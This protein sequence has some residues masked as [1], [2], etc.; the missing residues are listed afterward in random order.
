MARVT[1]FVPFIWAGLSRRP[2]RTVLGLVAVTMAF[3][4]YGLALGEAEGFA[5]AAAARHVDIGQGFLLG[6]L[7]VSAIGM[8]LILFLTANAMAQGVRLRIGE[9]G[10]LKAIGYSHRLILLLVMAEAA[11]PCLGGAV[12]GLTFAPLL[13]GLLKLLLP[14]L[15]IFPAL[16]YTPAMLATAA[17]LA[18]LIGA[19]SGALPA[20]R[21]IRLE[22][23]AA[24]AGGPMA[25]SRRETGETRQ[26]RETIAAAAPDGDGGLARVAKADLH[27][28]RQIIVV[29]RIGLSTLRYRIKGGLVIVVSIGVMA[30]VMLGFLSGAEGIKIG[31]LGSG[32]LD[33]V[34]IHQMARW[35]PHL[36]MWDSHLPDNAMTIAQAAPGVARGRNGAKLVVPL[37]YSGLHMIKR[38]NGNE[39]NT[40]LI[41]AGS[42]W[43]DATPGL[44]LLW[45]RM[46]HRGARELIAGRNALGKF[47][48]LDSHTVEYKKASWKIVGGF[49]TGDWWDGYLVGDIETVQAAAKETRITAL[50]VKLESPQAFTSFRQ[51]AQ[52]KLPSDIVVEREPDH[53]ASAWHSVPNNVFYIAYLLA[54]LIGV[55]AFAGT[56]QTMQSAVEARAREIAILR[57][58]GFDGMAVAASVVIEA[59]LL[60]TLGACLGTAI[61]WLWAD[62]FLYDGA[63]NI[64]RVTVDLP[65]LMEAVS[66]ALVIAL[67]GVLGPALR[68]A[69][70]TP[71]EALREAS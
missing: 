20:S 23:A 14:P 26:P 25:P 9:F 56:T 69:R 12:L 68:L 15:A 42:G 4:L 6:A 43:A 27:L 47:L 32:V 7:A 38:N 61:V 36:N 50:L 35:E 11:L 49:T 46:P 19:G 67:P 22:V 44:R 55:G 59:M 51:A 53:Y 41:G 34:L 48:T 37:L 18:V 54:G 60:A 63:G 45:G 52:P 8:A 24:L 16:V 66:W 40:T 71:I 30:F 31:L 65:L 2:L 3:T 57:A 58:L 17:A 29:T 64:F 21:I 70:Q 5:R 13:L 39:G 10:V 28:L 33:R 1:K 62:G